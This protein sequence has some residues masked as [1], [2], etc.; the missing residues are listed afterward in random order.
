MCFLSVPS[1]KLQIQEQRDGCLLK[2]VQL[3]VYSSISIRATGDLKRSIY[4]HWLAFPLVVTICFY[5]EQQW[6]I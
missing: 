4:I 1:P 3:T 2:H 5:T 6:S